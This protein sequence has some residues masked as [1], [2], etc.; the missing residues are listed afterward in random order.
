MKNRN[1]YVRMLLLIILVLCSNSSFSK[2]IEAKKSETQIIVDGK[3]DRSEWPPHIFQSG[4]IQMQPDK[5][6]PSLEETKVAVQ[7]D[8]SNIYIAFI[9]KKSY[10]NPIIA[11]Q[12]RRDQLGS[13]DDLV[14]VGL[15]TYNDSRSG[16][17]FVTNPLGTQHDW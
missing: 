14:A 3:I 13:S 15:D 17:F 16:Y 7:F 2:Q 6:A 10:P 1:I 5:G 8:Q 12:T 11:E 9:C 4:F